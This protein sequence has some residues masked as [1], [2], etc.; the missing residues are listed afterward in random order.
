MTG[1]AT[2]APSVHDLLLALAGHLDDDLLAWARELVAVGEENV[3]VELA[4]A[5]VAA[6]R[7]AL[8]PPVRTALV[9]AARDAHTDLDVD[10]ALPPAAP[11]AGT[12]HRFDADAAPG[13]AVVAALT[14]LPARRLSGCT[15]RL[16]WRRTPAGAAPG[17]LPHAVVLVEADADRSADVLAYLLAT[18]LDRA[19]APASVEVF[20]PGA[21][22][23]AYHAAALRAA[24]EI[25]RGPAV[26]DAPA[27]L[28]TDTADAARSVAPRH[29]AGPAPSLRVVPSP[30][31][32]VADVRPLPPGRRR[33]PE[34]TAAAEPR[35]D[36]PGDAAQSALPTTGPAT[37]LPGAA[38]TAI[39]TDHAGASRTEGPTTAHPSAAPPDP[40]VRPAR[41][42]ATARPG[43]ILPEAGVSRT[44]GSTALPGP[45]AAAGPDAVQTET[46]AP[47][48]GVAATA[49]L[50]ARPDPGATVYGVPRQAGPVTPPVPA[51]DPLSGPLRAPLLAPLL[52]P[53]GRGTGDGPD[54]PDGPAAPPCEP[55]SARSETGPPEPEP[56]VPA[57]TA[58]ELPEE[59]DDDWRSGEW[60]MPPAPP[61]PE[62]DAP[63]NRPA[64]D[65]GID[66]FGT[67]RTDP[68]D[69][70]P[71]PGGTDAVPAV[72]PRIPPASSS[73][74]SL[75]E[76]PTARVEPD[77][78][79]PR[80]VP[81]QIVSTHTVPTHTD[82]PPTGGSRVLPPRFDDP[83][84]GPARPEVPLFDAPDRPEAGPDEP[85]RRRR[86]PEPD[87]PA[88]S[89]PAEA[90]DP[91]ALL[92]GTERDL[93]AQLHAELTARD[94]RPRPYRRAAPNGSARPVNGHD[95]SGGP[96]GDRTPPDLAG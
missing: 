59:W 31:P 43:A 4:S 93:L 57:G 75:F 83:L 9:A 65:S 56:A 10:R 63:A 50:P 53:T 94:R 13:D 23:P 79:P 70:K 19:G 72:T 37:V 74:V 87:V 52:D 61:A 30:E 7:V 18:E 5:A 44:A 77:P 34:P 62:P 68:S 11:E 54:G 32:A 84:L 92:S 29:G 28:P 82:G 88:D 71:E 12:P 64:P 80:P 25:A 1:T 51:D 66:V 14:A 69:R 42:P 49:G 95:R 26:A 76:S 78:V 55:A 17:P 41:N 39:P 96:N 73:G 3:A 2:A 16:T 21:P 86:R 89:F 36:A 33:R 91:S 38:P 81:T 48:S 60:A 47:D 90:P 20:T 24:R 85:R 6:E 67:P 45:S 8:P 40:A 58:P 46:A 27:D 22:L 35:D 15:L